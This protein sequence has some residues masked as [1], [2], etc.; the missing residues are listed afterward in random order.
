MLVRKFI[1]HILTLGNLLSGVL[2]I[3]AL[4][5]WGEPAVAGL[6]I[7]IGATFDVFDGAVARWLK[8]QSPLGGQLDSMAD[9]VTFG[10]L[11]G[12]IAFTLIPVTVEGYALDAWLPTWAPYTALAIPAA[13]AWR[14]AVFNLDETQKTGFK[15]FPSPAVGLLWACIPLTLFTSSAWTIF[16]IQIECVDAVTNFD[17]RALTDVTAAQSMSELQQSIG[18]KFPPQL[19]PW[20]APLS[21]GVTYVVLALLSA[22]MMVSRV[23]LLSFKMPK[24]KRR[25]VWLLV[26]LTVIVTAVAIFVYQNPFAAIPIVLLLY[27]LIS[28]ATTLISPNNAVQSRD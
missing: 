25:P 20:W 2:G 24:G 26:V 8:V 21:H 11:P 28:V 22:V 27:L 1:P 12:L 14:L 6:L 9:I 18:G 17:F 4:F 15:G 23:P 13:A 3:I 16:G 10:V 19:D 7:L 5:V